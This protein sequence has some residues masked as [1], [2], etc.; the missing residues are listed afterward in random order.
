MNFIPPTHQLSLAWGSLVYLGIIYMRKL[1][2]VMSGCPVLTEV[3]AE[4]CFAKPVRKRIS[5]ITRASTFHNKSV[6]C[7]P[8]LY[9]G[10]QGMSY[11]L[12]LSLLCGGIRKHAF[13]FQLRYRQGLPKQFHTLLHGRY[14][15]TSGKNNR[16]LNFKGYPKHDT[17]IQH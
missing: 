7:F 3:K 16:N 11:S 8:A 2:L 15:H 14:Q 5:C 1:F 6:L 12:S 4:T 10:R 13:Q 9:L 17:N